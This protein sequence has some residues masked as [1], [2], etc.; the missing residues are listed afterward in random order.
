MMLV[1]LQILLIIHCVT[2]KAVFE[3]IGVVPN[4]RCS[5]V[6]CEDQVNYYCMAYG[7][8]VDTEFPNVELRTSPSCFRRKE[9]GQYCLYSSGNIIMGNGQ[10]K[11]ENSICSSKY[12]CKHVMTP[13]EK[14]HYQRQKCHRQNMK[15]MQACIERMN[16]LCNFN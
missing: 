5:S 11:G 2:S 6:N 4:E 8:G 14:C 7:I 9:L 10:C 15:K 3:P 13:I 1:Y 12:K 16:E